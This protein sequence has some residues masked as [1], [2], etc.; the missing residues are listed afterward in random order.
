M[1]NSDHQHQPSPNATGAPLAHRHSMCSIAD[2]LLPI[3][4]PS[5]PMHS[6]NTSFAAHCGCPPLSPSD[7]PISNAPSFPLT[8]SAAPFRPVLCSNTAHVPNNS[9][10]AAATSKITIRHFRRTSSSHC[11]RTN[12]TCGAYRFRCVGGGHGSPCGCCRSRSYFAG[13]RQWHSYFCATALA[14]IITA[15]TFAFATLLLGLRRPAQILTWL[16]NGTA[17]PLA[18][19]WASTPAGAS[20]AA[21]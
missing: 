15:F 20:A 14:A 19:R 5:P 9:T 4:L 18:A 7:F 17:S 21:I 11:V 16:S 3:L 12:R 1:N 8:P 6:I 10:A 13:R 2:H